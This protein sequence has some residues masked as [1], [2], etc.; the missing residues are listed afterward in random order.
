MYVGNKRVMFLNVKN[1]ASL[2]HNYNVFLFM[3]LGGGGGVTKVIKVIDG[4]SVGG[5]YG[6]GNG[7]YGGGK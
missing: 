7:G 6:G 4:G 5:G 1:L 2:I 3:L